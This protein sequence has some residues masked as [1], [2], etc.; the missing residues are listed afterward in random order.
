MQ[1]VFTNDSDLA[2]GYKASRD[3]CLNTFGS[4]LLQIVALVAREEVK[5]LKS[6]GLIHSF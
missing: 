5:V 2:F 3:E 1:L 6:L 4:L